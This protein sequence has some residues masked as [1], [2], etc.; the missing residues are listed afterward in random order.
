MS[1]IAMKNPE[2]PAP[3][4]MAADRRAIGIVRVSTSK[5]G[6]GNSP[7]IQRDGIGRYAREHGLSLVA[8]EEIHESGKDADDRPEF[9]RAL[10][11]VRTEK[12]RH[13]IFWVTD[14]IGRNMTDYERLE[15]A[16]RSGLV[17]LHIAADGRVL[18]RGSPDGD[19]LAADL[20]TL[21]AKHYARDLRRRSYEGMTRRAESGF[22]PA[23][24]PFGYQNR[25]QIGADGQVRDREGIIIPRSWG[26]EVVRRMYEL[27]AEG[28]SLSAIH[29]ALASERRVDEDGRPLP[30][31][32]R[33]RI[34]RIL[35]DPFYKGE[36][37]WN[38]RRY[39]G[40]HE[41]FVSAD[42]WERV[43]ETF[44]CG[45]AAGRRRQRTPALAG[46]LKCGECGCQITY[47][48]KTKRG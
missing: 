2:L 18:H 27:R 26:R 14:R 17:V 32:G 30:T 11:R 12:V 22:L 7:G 13:I 9:N 6:D 10:E 24:A 48:P 36:F 16:V 47:D 33:S 28:L 43:Q 15:K 39:Q 42:E 23:K 1:K 45:P 5:Q 4:W 34:E 35:K 20:S 3:E 21:T 25:K 29:E 19:W 40:Q 41:T 46:F 8:V 38:G 44:G 31:V 37:H